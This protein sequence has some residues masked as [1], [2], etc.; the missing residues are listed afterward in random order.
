MVDLTAS[1]PASTA[2][3]KP[4]PCAMFYVD[5]NKNGII[6]APDF[7]SVMDLKPCDASATAVQVVEKGRNA[8][9]THAHYYM[10]GEYHLVVPTEQAC[11]MVDALAVESKNKF[12]FALEWASPEAQSI[13]DTF[14]ASPRA[15]A[16]RVKLHEAMIEYFVGNY[17]SPKGLEYVRA[18]DWTRLQNGDDEQLSALTDDEGNLDGSKYP[19]TLENYQELIDSQ[20]AALQEYIPYIAIMDRVAEKGGDLH[21]IDVDEEDEEKRETGM[22][23]KMQALGSRYEYILG[24][25]GATHVAEYGAPSTAAPPLPSP[26]RRGSQR[27]RAMTR[28]CP[29]A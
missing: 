19:K 29:S 28:C 2:P 25:N 21:C 16:D 14:N 27:Q 1:T 3:S 12:A 5:A 20:V 7:D 8:D 11:A 17:L 23:G 24:Y 13:F 10:F 15:E 6:D 9:G 22:T 26:W 4:D 18:M